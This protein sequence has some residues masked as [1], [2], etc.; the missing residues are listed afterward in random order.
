MGPTT[1]PLRC[2]KSRRVEETL[3]DEG[4]RVKYCWLCLGRSRN[5]D[6][7]E[8]SGGGSLSIAGQTMR[9]EQTRNGNTTPRS[10]QFPSSHTQE[11]ASNGTCRE[12]GGLGGVKPGRHFDYHNAEA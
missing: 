2:Y 3:T 5:A 9:A 12:E 10:P 4:R 7:G 6:V 11:I 1:E 8:K